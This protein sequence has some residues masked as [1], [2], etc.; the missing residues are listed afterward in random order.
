MQDG[1][2]RHGQNV[3]IVD[4]LIAT[5]VCIFSPHVD[6]VPHPCAPP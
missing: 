5:G 2:I 6:I 4:D 1:V 3:I